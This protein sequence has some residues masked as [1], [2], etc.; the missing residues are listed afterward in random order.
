MARDFLF[1]PTN[2]TGADQKPNTGTDLAGNKRAQDVIVLNP[3]G[4]PIPVYITTGA[5]TAPDTAPSIFNVPCALTTVEY[6][7]A[8][9]ANTKKFVLRARKHSKIQFAYAPLAVNYLTIESGVSLE[10]IN[11]YI[12]A[13]LY[14]KCSK[15]DEVVEI[16]AYV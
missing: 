16:V 1:L 5:P 14:F 8:L 2:A 4:S 3:V 10:D 12:G 6:S 9:P 11:P 15:A 7:Q 13:T